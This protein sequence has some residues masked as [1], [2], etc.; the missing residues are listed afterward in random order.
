MIAKI[1]DEINEAN[2]QLNE[3]R[4]SFSLV[5]RNALKHLASFVEGVQ[6]SDSFDLIIATLRE[7]DLSNENLE[8]VKNIKSII[9][10]EKAALLRREERLEKIIDDRSHDRSDL[11]HD[12]SDL[13]QLSK[14]PP[15]PI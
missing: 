9:E 6:D 12:R 7:N 8:M 4:S 11:I 1:Q 14:I 13:I 10:A 5:K 3:L 2:F 15:H